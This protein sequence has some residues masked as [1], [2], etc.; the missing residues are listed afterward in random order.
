MDYSLNRITRIPGMN[1]GIRYGTRNALYF[2]VTLSLSETSSELY[3][4]STY[5]SILNHTPGSNEVSTSNLKGYSYGTNR[6]DEFTR[7][8]PYGNRVVAH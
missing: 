3:L 8:V 2:T 7:R 1:I 4:P 6:V 5:G